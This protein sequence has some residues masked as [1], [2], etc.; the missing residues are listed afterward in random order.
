MLEVARKDRADGIATAQ[1]RAGLWRNALA[2]EAR[3]AQITA[4]K[5]KE[6]R[7]SACVFA[8]ALDAQKALYEPHPPVS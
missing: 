2:A 1:D 7:E 8:L 6:K 3:T 4:R 5:A